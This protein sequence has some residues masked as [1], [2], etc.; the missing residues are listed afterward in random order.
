[1]VLKFLEVTKS[2]SINKN[3]NYAKKLACLIEKL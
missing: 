1:M 3:L 2:V